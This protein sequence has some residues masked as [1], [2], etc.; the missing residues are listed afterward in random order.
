MA[1][2]THRLLIAYDFLEPTRTEVDNKPLYAALESLGAKKIQSSVWIVRTE[3][4][5]ASVLWELD[6][7][8]G[9]ADHLFIAQIGD[10][11]NR[12]RA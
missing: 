3:L 1:N 4:S 11:V 5:I 9:N 2:P 7:Y 12:K 10:S 6:G 8:F